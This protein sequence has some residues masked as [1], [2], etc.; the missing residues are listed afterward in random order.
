VFL[1]PEVLKHVVGLLVSESAREDL[2]V[3]ILKQITSLFTIL[4]KKFLTLL[5]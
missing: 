2:R 4:Q 3:Q 1:K 5:E